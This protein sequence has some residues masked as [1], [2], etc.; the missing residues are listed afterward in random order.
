M[1]ALAR[2][3][4]SGLEGL[5]WILRFYFSWWQRRP[6]FFVQSSKILSVLLYHLF[7]FLSTLQLFLRS[8]PP[9]RFDGFLGLSYLGCLTIVFFCV[10]TNNASTRRARIRRNST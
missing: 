10:E 6:F 5:V 9:H 2:L 4:I 1:S 7:S 8:I 3:R